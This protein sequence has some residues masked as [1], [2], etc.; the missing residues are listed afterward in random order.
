MSIRREIG[1]LQ[2][3]KKNQGGV[4]GSVHPVTILGK[5]ALTQGPTYI[6]HAFLFCIFSGVLTSGA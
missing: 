3:Q 6:N 5:S 4:H 1:P 2:N